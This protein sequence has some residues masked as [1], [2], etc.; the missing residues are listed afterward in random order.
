MTDYEKDKAIDEF[1]STLEHDY[2]NLKTMSKF[3]THEDKRGEE[4]VNSTLIILR[5]KINAIINSKT[6]KDV[7]K[8][9][10]LKKL[11]KKHGD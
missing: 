8:H 11:F 1:I 2:E 3:M 10:K 5:N 9:V 7:K 4:L 6:H